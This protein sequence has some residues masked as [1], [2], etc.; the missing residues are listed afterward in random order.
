MNR[1]NVAINLL[2]AVGSLLLVALAA[3]GALRFV[4][5]RN[6]NPFERDANLQYRLKASFG[7]L[8]PRTPVRT[9]EN[10]RRIPVDATESAGERLLFI[11]DSVTFG[12][13]VLAEEAYAYRLGEILDD[14]AGI[15]IAA[16]PGYNLEQVIGALARELATRQPEI[17]VYGLVLNDVYGTPRPL[18]YEEI[19]PHAGRIAEG[20]FLANSLLIAFVQR[21]WAR[22]ASSFEDSAERDGPRRGTLEQLESSLPVGAIEAFD[23]QWRELEQLQCRSSC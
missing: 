6:L 1:R 15:A 17:V 23:E 8:Y 2:L 19:D 18:T 13:G 5:L 7:G 11:G 14:V 4:L 9:D 21:R 22:I 12:F 16:V 10:R 3:E 20:G